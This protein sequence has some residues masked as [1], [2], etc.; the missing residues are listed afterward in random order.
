LDGELGVDSL[1]V[2]EGCL[3]GSFFN[4]AS[5]VEKWESAALMSSTGGVADALPGDDEEGGFEETDLRVGAK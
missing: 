4:K 2:V 5:S 3:E 1:V